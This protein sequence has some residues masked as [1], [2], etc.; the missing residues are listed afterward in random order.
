MDVLSKEDNM[1]SIEVV[2]IMGSFTIQKHS[3]TFGTY[4]SRNT[5]K[6]NEATKVLEAKLSPRTMNIFKFYPMPHG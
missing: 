6:K 3:R 5:E 4:N 2:Q 1:Q